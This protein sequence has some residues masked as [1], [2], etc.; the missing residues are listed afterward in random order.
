M[1]P[2]PPA[3]L[4]LAVL[5]LA[6]VA[7]TAQDSVVIYRCTDARGALTVQNDVPCPKGSRQERRVFEI[8]PASH[9]PAA[10]PSPPPPAPAPAPAAPPAPTIEIAARLPPPALYECSTPDDRRYFS[11]D[12]TPPE[13]CVPLQTTGIGGNPGLGAGTACERVT[14]QCRRVPDEDLCASWRQ[15]LHDA[16]TALRFGRFD[17]RATAQADVARFAHVASEST[18][19]G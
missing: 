4:L 12:G 17:N 1:P 11:D 15:R 18:C 19:G 5:V 6:P 13:R 16:E 2:K 3:A 7:V 14:D 9:A 10:P 8:A